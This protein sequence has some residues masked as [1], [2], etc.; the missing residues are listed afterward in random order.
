L[1][2]GG[3]NW[4]FEESKYY[5]EQDQEWIQVKNKKSLN[6]SVFKRL[7]F[8]DSNLGRTGNSSVSV[9]TV[10]D[11]IKS[12]VP[13]GASNVVIFFINPN[14]VSSF[15]R[16]GI[17]DKIKTG[18]IWVLKPPE[19]QPGAKSE[20]KLPC[21]LPFMKFASF[22]TVEWPDESYQNWFKA[23]GPTIQMREVSSLKEFGQFYLGK[24]YNLVSSSSWHT[25]QAAESIAHHYPLLLS[26]SGSFANGEHSDRSTAVRA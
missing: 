18:H 3:S 4:N 8:P 7:S 25:V 16:A 23:H 5:R 17:L 9:A 19:R 24:K 20:A 6:S 22:P 2:E 21:L 1:G 10:F 11:C 13:N 15:G 14:N 26:G 12:V